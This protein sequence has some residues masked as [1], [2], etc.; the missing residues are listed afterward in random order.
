MEPRANPSLVG[1]EPAERALMESY[2]S[3]RLAHAWLLTGPSG[4]GKATL[5]F[6]FARFLLA[7]NHGQASMSMA[8]DPA[9]PVFRR[10]ASGGHADLRVLAREINPRTGKLR[11]EIV[12]EQVRDAIAALRLTP[13]EGGWRIAIVDGAEDMNRNSQ[14]ALLKILEEPPSRAVLLLVC[15]A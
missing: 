9:H 15:H 6:R 10:V 14:N 13:S 12:I 2:G 11:S 1:Q 8:L 3:G 4:V 7:G 5:A